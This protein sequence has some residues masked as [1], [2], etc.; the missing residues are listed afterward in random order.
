MAT[1]PLTLV[2]AQQLSNAAATY[3]TSTSIKTRIEKATV[4][5]NDT[6]ARTVTIHIVASGGSES[7]SNRIT[8][9]RSIAAGETWHCGDLVGH[10]M[11]VDSTLRALASANTA[12]TFMVSGS[13]LS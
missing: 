5:N 2:A 3:Y 4:T 1:T 11:P 10:I 9:A 8:N 7:A 12:L 6:V 13:Q